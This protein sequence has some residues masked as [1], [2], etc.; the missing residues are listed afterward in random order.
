MQ[1]NSG[2]RQAEA[3]SGVRGV[4]GQAPTWSSCTGFKG[5]AKGQ[6][7][8][9][10]LT[11]IPTG[12]LP[13]PA[14]ELGKPGSLAA[15]GMGVSLDGEGDGHI[16]M[17]GVQGTECTGVQGARGCRHYCG[18]CVCCGMEACLCQ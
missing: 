14:R 9:G 6:P 4:W 10:S 15:G 7:D 18:S 5:K 8:P 17:Q 12:L 11:L 3:G 2:A 16:G 13:A 1:A